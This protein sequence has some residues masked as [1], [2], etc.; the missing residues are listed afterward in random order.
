MK[1]LLIVDVQKGLMD[2][3]IYNK[4]LLITTINNA[5]SSYESKKDSIVFIQHNSKML[6][7]D[8][9]DWEIDNSL[10]YT[11]NYKR[12]QKVHGNAFEK[13]ELKEYLKE[14][15]IKEILVCGLVSHG[16]VRATCIGGKEEGFIV[17]ILKNGHSCWSSDAK[18]RIESIEKELEALGIRSSKE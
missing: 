10:V 9:N 2:K 18:E 3:K 7:K 8:T 11:G 6:T 12:V 15:G 16:C 17:K 5:I 1:A 14:K 4:E 13:T